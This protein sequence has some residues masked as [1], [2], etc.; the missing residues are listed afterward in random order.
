M[1]IIT[2]LLLMIST[3]VLAEQ[4]GDFPENFQDKE[5]FSE[6]GTWKPAGKRGLFFL[7]PSNFVHF[8]P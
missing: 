7:S 8:H 6:T 4:G 5:R 2:I 3:Q 1:K